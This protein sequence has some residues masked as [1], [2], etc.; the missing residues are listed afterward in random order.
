MDKKILVGPLLGL[1]SDSLYAV[2]FSTSNSVADASVCFNGRDVMARCVGTAFNTRVWR[3]EFMV[4][5]QLE[6]RLVRYEICVGGNLARNQVENDEW[7]FFV[8][9]SHEKPRILYASCNGFSTPSS[10]TNA[11]RPYVLWGKIRKFQFSEISKVSTNDIPS[12][13]SLMLLGGN[14]VYADDL[15]S[16]V[17]LLSKWSHYSL[18][19]KCATKSTKVLEDQLERFY[20]ELYISRWSDPDMSVMLATIPNVMMWDSNDI[21]GGWGSYPKELQECQ[22]FKKIFEVAK[23]FFEL[24]QIRSRHNRSLLDP[25][26]EHYALGLCFR[27]YQ[28][29]ALDNVSGRTKRG[30]MSPIQW[31]VVKQY[32]DEKVVVGDLLLMTS[33][34]VVYRNFAFREDYYEYSSWEDEL[35]EGLNDYWNAKFHQD[36]RAYL[37]FSL[38]T[39]IPNREKNGHCNTVILS[40]HVLV[41]CLGVINDRRGS[42]PSKI[43]QVVSSGIVH[44]APSKFHWAGIVANSSDDIEYLLA[45]RTVDISMI[46]PYGSSKYILS[47]NYVSLYEGTD[48]KLWVNWICDADEKPSYPVG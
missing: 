7:T 35:A 21:F 34:P 24:L 12:P 37:I 40:G 32:L 18:S 33:V 11:G 22:I 47:R 28:I 13:Y 25:N 42:K 31:T 36:E 41:G 8:P 19:K 15:W 16:K 5:P 39:N 30:V 6:S 4:Q 45:E 17:P 3:A 20:H 26:G 27:G 10:A 1:E 2:C 9:G 38:L 46:K 48:G 29:L 44:P 23:R 14:Q 43:F